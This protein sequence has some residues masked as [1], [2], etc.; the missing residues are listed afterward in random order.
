VH[1]TASGEGVTTGRKMSG[2]GSSAGRRQ[3]SRAVPALLRH[4]DGGDKAADEGAVQAEVGNTDASLCSTE[5]NKEVGSETLVATRRTC[6][7]LRTRRNAEG[8]QI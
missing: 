8:R 6:S 5:L 4:C 1:T 3:S 2:N 7:D